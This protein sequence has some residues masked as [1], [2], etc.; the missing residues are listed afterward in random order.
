MDEPENKCELVC[1]SRSKKNL[2]VAFVYD[3]MR[4]ILNTLDNS[5]IENCMK[6]CS[7]WKEIGESI[8]RGRIT[9]AVEALPRDIIAITNFYPEYVVR[10]LK[11]QNGNINILTGYNG[12]LEENEERSDRTKIKRHLSRLD[13]QCRNNNNMK[14]RRYSQR[15]IKLHSSPSRNLLPICIA[16]FPQLP[17]LKISRFLFSKDEIK[18][19]LKPGPT[20]FTELT[21]ISKEETKC[22]L[23]IVDGVLDDT[24]KKVI[25][26]CA[27][28]GISDYSV[29][30][31]YRC[32]VFS[33][34]MVHALS[35]NLPK[36]H[37]LQQMK[38]TEL[39]QYNIAWN[40]CI[41]LY[42]NQKFMNWCNDRSGFPEL[43]I[44]SKEFHNIPILFYHS[45]VSFG[46]E[47]I[48]NICENTSTIGECTKDASVLAK[49]VLLWIA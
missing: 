32:I 36:D 29:G 30:R 49:I 9:I 47:Y 18:E 35:F 12:Y 46:V 1:K 44:F 10:Y 31:A 25:P 19:K 40:N 42:F 27:V 16:V 24:F 45:F 2:N 6:V 38:V 21:D 20:W 37:T 7:L 34:R 5:E 22:V 23:W 48:P 15:L 8:L 26:Q 28:S 41:L 39:K 4:R 43:E 13:A 17:G 3:I 14:D 33:G 11:T